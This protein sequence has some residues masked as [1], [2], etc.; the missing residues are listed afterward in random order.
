M[1]K[2]IF[3]IALCS[4][5]LV[6]LAGCGSAEKA[7]EPFTLR[8]G[9]TWGMPKEEILNLAKQE[10]LLGKESKEDILAKQ[11]RLL[12]KE[13]KEDTMIFS[14][15]PVGGFSA[16]MRLRF[17]VDMGLE[18]VGYFF[19]TVPKEECMDMFSTLTKELEALYGVYEAGDDGRSNNW[20]LHDTEIK[21]AL[22]YGIIDTD[23]GLEMGS[24]EMQECYIIYRGHTPITNSGL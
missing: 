17:D 8:N 6:S 19:P 12:G 2:R 23:D 4:C 14:E 18:A 24:E 22:L 15:V 13:S 1:M 5:L 9:Y 11:E 20:Q 3:L 10:R 16:E 7:N 21:I